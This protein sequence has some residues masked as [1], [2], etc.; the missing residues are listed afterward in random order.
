MSLQ[1]RKTLSIV[2]VLVIFAFTAIIFSQTKETSII[3]QREYTDM[4]VEEIQRATDKALASLNERLSSMNEFRAS[5][6]DANKMFV[7]KETVDKM[8]EDI[9]ELRTISDI[10]KGAATQGQFFIS[11]IAAFIGMFGGIVGLV[12]NWKKFNGN[13]K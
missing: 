2:F 5:I 1:N 4:R 6:N 9:R 8:Q 13:K 3:T 7:T 10:A 11:M 12:L